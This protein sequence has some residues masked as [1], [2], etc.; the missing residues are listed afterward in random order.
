MLI[1]EAETLLGE[2]RDPL[3]GVLQGLPDCLCR[4]SD[5][6]T[7][8]HGLIDRQ[9]QRAREVLTHDAG[10]GKQTGLRSDDFAGRMR[11]RLG[12]LVGHLNQLPAVVPS[13]LA[14]RLQR[15][16]ELGQ[17]ILGVDRLGDEHAQHRTAAE[18]AEPFREGRHAEVNAGDG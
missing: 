9:L 15:S 18:R 2:S 5:V 12:H 8:T 16:I 7:Q 10:V 13:G 11:G 14:G 3:C 4:L 6:L 1:G 17:L